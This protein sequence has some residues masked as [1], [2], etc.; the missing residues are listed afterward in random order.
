MP[1][2][3][4]PDYS[5]SYFAIATGLGIGL[6]VF[7]LTRNTLPHTGDNI[8][9]LPHGGRYRDGTKRIDYCGPSSKP[10]FYSNSKNIP[11]LIVFTIVAV[12]LYLSRESWNTKKRKICLLCSQNCQHPST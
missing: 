11:F 8:H 9:H 3:P 7:L 12:I 5:N 6:S 1:L 4:P 10:D 2:T